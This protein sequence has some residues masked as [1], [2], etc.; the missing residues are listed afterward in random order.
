ML[1]SSPES[2]CGS[3]VGPSRALRAVLLALVLAFAGLQLSRSPYSASEFRLV[4]DS[5]E[6]AIVARRLATEGRYDFELDGVAYPPGNSSWFPV[7]IAPVF[8]LAP[9]ELG[10]AV[11]PVFIL[12]LL[13]LLCA[14]AVATRLSNPVGGVLAVLALV[15]QKE[16]FAFA[17]MVMSDVPALAFMLWACLLYLPASQRG[18]PTV[19][20]WRAGIAIAGA[21]ALRS[22]FLVL[23]LPFALR[24][25]QAV[26]RKASALVSLAAPTFAVLVATWVY[27]QQTF[28]DWRRGGFQYWLSVP[29]D[30]L[31][32]VFS[33]DYFSANWAV[34]ARPSALTTLA[35]GCL[36][37]LFLWR[38]KVTGARA[39]A[40]FA[41][42][43]ALPISVVHLFYYYPAM[44]FHLPSLALCCIAGAAGIAALLPDWGER[45]Q[46][47]VACALAA[48]MLFLP[49]AQDPEPRRRQAAEAIFA[50][51]PA[52]ATIVT[53]LDGVYLGA[54][55]PG[56][57][58]RTYV[59]ISRVVEYAAGL[60]T[61]RRIPDPDP[62][63]KDA[64]DRRS[65][66]LLRA[67]AYDVYPLTAA[68]AIPTIV[69]W[70][71]EGR[72]VYLDLT[73]LKDQGAVDRLA[74]GGL[75]LAPLSAF[76]SLRRLELRRVGGK[77][78]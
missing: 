17:R 69:Q 45:R 59:P 1:P 2:I 33:S 5:Q 64:F 57:S 71:R 38:R 8:W 19:R 78:Q 65:P 40:E 76:P 20:P 26:P 61:P 25:L 42:L 23:L 4:P 55:E 66:G 52:D 56:D 27:Q 18:A 30:Y 35:L 37:G 48:A 15:E 7:L 44:R 11:L 10:N 9:G 51:T 63:P 13:G 73:A 47:L 34:F 68:E 75:E 43:A 24:W 74:A 58:R 21:F 72:A 39:L 16:F 3:G 6:Y 54:L 77:G 41:G 22:L 36:G 53:G 60:V 32:L 49:R 67:G 28:G 46:Y 29:Y 12:S 31:S 70:V 50:A 62:P 14:F